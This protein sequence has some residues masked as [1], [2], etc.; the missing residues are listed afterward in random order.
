LAVVEEQVEQPGR[1]GRWI[2]LV[3]SIPAVALGVVV[4]W[5][6]EGVYGF[7]RDTQ[8]N[9]EDTQWRMIVGCRFVAW[10]ALLMAGLQIGLCAKI[11]KSLMAPKGSRSPRLKFVWMGIVLLITLSVFWGSQILPTVNLMHA[12]R[13]P[14]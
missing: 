3:M 5:K 1:A 2:G 8:G 11:L 6:G 10:A 14:K 7:L 12:I 13:H 4:G 9:Y